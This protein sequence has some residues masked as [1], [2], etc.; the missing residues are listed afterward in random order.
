V[1]EEYLHSGDNTASVTKGIAS[2]AR[3]IASAALIMISVFFGFVLGTDPI[4]KMMGVGLAV[5]VFL[6]A[7]I[8][9]LVLVPATMKLMG[10]ANWWL[11]GWLDRILP[12]L[13]IEGDSGLPAP[14]YRAGVEVPAVAAPVPEAAEGDEAD[15]VTEDAPRPEV[16]VPAASVPE[17]VFFDIVT[18]DDRDPYL[19]LVADV[20]EIYLGMPLELPGFVPFGE[21]LP[22]PAEPAYASGDDADPDLPWDPPHHPDFARSG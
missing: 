18:A 6:D 22:G 5:A 10:H 7:T 14:V 4:V 17:P 9:R 19:D 20:E 11:P 12:N 16:L 21:L 8:V 13:D 15:E 2:T 1:R 3:V